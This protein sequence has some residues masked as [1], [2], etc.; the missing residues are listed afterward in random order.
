MNISF[1][2]ILLLSCL[3][4]TVGLY[5][6]SKLKKSSMISP[7]NINDNGVI[8]KTERRVRYSGKYPKKFI[9]KYKE[10]SKNSSTISRVLSKGSTPAGQH[11]SIMIDE[12]I[13]HMG[14]QNRTKN[15]IIDCTLGGGG[16]TLR[17]LRETN[18][19]CNL[20]AFDKDILELEKTT[21]RINSLI[22][23]K[24]QINYSSNYSNL[25]SNQIFQPNHDSFG[26]AIN[27]INN[28]NLTGNIHA[29][30]ADLGYSSMQI[31]D[32][33]RGFTYKYDGHLDMRMDTSQSLTALKL[34]N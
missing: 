6:F 26:N 27:Y 9:E 29:I 24:L 25:I 10:I 32:P 34:L 22:H 11:V 19:N 23:K 2:L 12:C 17:I 5:D 18:L 15:N 21:E 1:I 30:I 3:Y 14:L 7:I 28:L 33:T 20:I 4:F 16:H 8:L 13:D 31:D